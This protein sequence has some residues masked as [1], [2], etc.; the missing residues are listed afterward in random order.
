MLYKLALKRLIDFV[1]AMFGSILIFPI[2]LLIY[3]L[4]LIDYKSSPFFYQVRAGKEGKAF[5]IFKFKTM[6]DLKDSNGNLL[7]DHERITKI[8][9]ILRKTSLDE[10]PQ[11]FNVIKG[12][13]SL[14]GPRPLYLKYL[15]YYTKK[16]S[17]RHSVKPGITGLAQISGR[18]TIGWNSRLQK[19]VEYVEKLSFLLDIKIIF[20]TIEKVL[21]S[22]DVATE[23]ESG[24]LDLDMERKTKI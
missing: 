12:E 14:I 3:L 13:M 11:L 23:M 21:L 5:K 9:G 4:L 24:I 10:I 19:D 6:N 20:K 8:G 22:K 2:F 7:P 18:N 1:L 15:P 16:E 17:I